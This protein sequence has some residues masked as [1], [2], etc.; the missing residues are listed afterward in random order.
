MV[1]GVRDS[2]SGNTSTSWIIS[3]GISNNSIGVTV[4]KLN[5]IGIIL[6][7]D[8]INNVAITGFL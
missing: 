6:Y 7:Q 1:K 8:V 4:G 3:Y 5:A 2:G